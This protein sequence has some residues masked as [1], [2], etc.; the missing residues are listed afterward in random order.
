MLTGSAQDESR[1]WRRSVDFGG[2][3][4]KSESKEG[5]CLGQ[6][7][8]GVEGNYVMAEVIMREKSGYSGA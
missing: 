1:N 6:K 7:K 5:G 4:S 3:G 8:E 2:R